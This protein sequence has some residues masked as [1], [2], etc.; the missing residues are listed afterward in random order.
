MVEDRIKFTCYREDNGK[1]K[2]VKTKVVGE[3][4]S[5][6]YEGTFDGNSTNLHKYVFVICIDLLIV[7]CESH[8]IVT[9]V[10]CGSIKRDTTYLYLNCSYYVGKY[11]QESGK[12]D[13]YPLP[14]I[15]S[16]KQVVK[17]YTASAVADELNGVDER[18]KRKILT[19]AFG[20]KIKKR[21][22]NAYEAGQVDVNSLGASSG[23]Q[24]HNMCHCSC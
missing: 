9:I 19:Q 17:S 18:E 5:I 12:V 24:Y 2:R 23:M 6:K 14:H 21:Q 22:Q 10:T 13:I 3:S 16:M 1:K 8:C 15:Y 20:S 11:N 7:S 4:E